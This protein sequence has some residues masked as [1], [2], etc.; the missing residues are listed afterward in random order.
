MGLLLQLLDN[1]QDLPQVAVALLCI[2][3]A[4]AGADMFVHESADPVA[5]LGLGGA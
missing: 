1:R 5:P 2:I 4:N 3:F